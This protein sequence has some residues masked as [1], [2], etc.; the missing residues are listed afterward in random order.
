MKPFT[1]NSSKILGLFFFAVVAIGCAEN[2]PNGPSR[3]CPACETRAGGETSDLGGEL[4]PCGAVEGR[5]EID[6]S[7]AE[8]L[9]FDVGELRR[10]IERDVDAELRWEAWDL[11]L[12]FIV[13]DGGLDG[14]ASDGS[15][16]GSA[17]EGSDGVDGVEPQIT[18]RPASG[19]EEQTRVSA[20]LSVTGYAYYRPDPAFCDG[21]TCSVPGSGLQVEEASCPVRLHVGFTVSLSTADGAIKATAD[22]EAIKWREGFE[23]MIDSAAKEVVGHAT[24]D[25]SE[26]EGNMRLYP[27]TDGPY[28]G[29]LWIQLQFDEDTTHGFVWPVIEYSVFDERG[30]EALVLYQPVRGE[31]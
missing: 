22:G 10:R 26:V 17:D 19:Y 4:T 16:D 25:L 11:D 13:G 28:S 7:E 12:E 14:T 20:S 5:L 2:E 18:G 21:G 27:G 8:Q 1:P 23:E 15:S 6:A 31:W 29:T 3:V 9:G 24:A 30:D